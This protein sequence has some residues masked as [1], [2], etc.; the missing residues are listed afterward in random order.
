MEPRLQERWLANRKGA[1]E[2]DRGFA[3]GRVVV[4][5]LGV[6]APSGVGGDA[7]WALL[8]RGESAVRPVT[9]F[10]VRE[11]PVRIAAQIPE[12]RPRQFMTALKARTASRFCQLTIAA[13]RLAADDA[14]FGNDALASPRAGFFLGTSAGAM[15]VGEDHGALFREHGPGSVPSTFPFVVSPHSASA[16]A[17]SDFGITGP[18]VTLSSECPAGVDAMVVGARQIRSGELDVAVVGGADAPITPLLFAGFARSGVL[19]HDNEHPWNA[20][21]PFDRDRGGIVLGEAAAMLVIEDR[22]RALE[23]GAHIYGEL[24]GFGSGRDR[25]TYVGD[26]DPSGRG[27][28]LAATAAL[29]DAGRCATDIDHVSAHAPG[30][31]MTDLA[32]MRALGALF[33]DSP[34]RP[35]VT[36]IKGALGHALAAAGVLQAAAALFALRDGAVPPTANCDQPDPECRL[37]IVRHSERHAA[38]RTALVTTHGFGGNTTSL[39]LGRAA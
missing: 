23:R 21:R 39:V 1:S 37:D 10:D 3:G 22:E 20:S 15:Q 8:R 4:T 17:A 30:A 7:L 31:P 6:V 14:R 2:R 27:F 18:I 25:P 29:E 16:M 36:S 13:S 9:R 34:R 35:A 12:F 28:L 24:L 5:G 33:A 19:A 38:L 11:Y 32:E 26:A